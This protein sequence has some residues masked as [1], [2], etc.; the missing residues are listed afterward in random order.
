M[1]SNQSDLNK[2][3][4]SFEKKNSLTN[5]S[6][7]ANLRDTL[8]V[9]NFNNNNTSNNFEKKRAIN[10]RV[11]E[12]Q[13]YEFPNIKTLNKE[14][15]QK[16][17]TKESGDIIT[18]VKQSNEYLRTTNYSSFKNEYVTTNNFGNNATFNKKETLSK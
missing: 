3:K 1:N 6:N 17:Y 8:N 16:I 9:F 4:K 5:N 12:K 15:N 13:E 11:K 18:A 2:T 7:L 10:V 14:L